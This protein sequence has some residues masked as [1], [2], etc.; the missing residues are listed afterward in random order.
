MEGEF[1]KGKSRTKP[2]LIQLEKPFFVFEI[3]EVV[4]QVAQWLDKK[5]GILW[6]ATIR[7]PEEAKFMGKEGNNDFLALS[8][9]INE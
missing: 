9:S 2:D 1:Y 3:L 7:R 4:T 8:F 6:Q 5:I